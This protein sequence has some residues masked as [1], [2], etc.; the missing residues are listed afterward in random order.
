MGSDDEMDFYYDEDEDEVEEDEMPD[1]DD[2]DYGELEG[3]ASL[4]S[5]KGGGSS[6]DDPASLVCI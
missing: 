3:D 6:R 2:P 1:E 4:D 5:D